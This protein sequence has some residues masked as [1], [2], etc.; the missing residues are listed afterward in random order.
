MA[1]CHEHAKKQGA[2]PVDTLPQDH[3]EDT[4]DD[5]AQDYPEGQ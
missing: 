2:A 5:Q 4:G 1:S 3:K